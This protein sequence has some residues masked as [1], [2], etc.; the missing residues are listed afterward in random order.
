[1]MLQLDSI[2]QAW[3]LTLLFG[4]GVGSV[5]I[6]RWLWERINL[7]SEIGAMAVSILLAPMLLLWGGRARAAEVDPMTIEATNILMMGTVS[8]I[9]AIGITFITPR[10]Q[11][12]L[13]KEFYERV[14]PAGFW[15]NTAIMCGDS[16]SRAPRE[17]RRELL[18]TAITALSLFLCLYGAGRLLIPHPD[19][20]TAWPLLALAAGLGLAP[21]WIRRAGK[22]PQD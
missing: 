12:E 8:T 21:V 11:P 7:W 22:R 3:E 1:V 19:V 6:L 15:R 17:L 16:P 14:R 10:T 18:T 13:L 5:L 2:G 9:V 4:A 20:A